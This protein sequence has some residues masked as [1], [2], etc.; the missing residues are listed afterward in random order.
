M[1][2]VLA[3]ALGLMAGCGI[4]IVIMGLLAMRDTAKKIKI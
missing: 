1:H 2:T 4:G 3:F